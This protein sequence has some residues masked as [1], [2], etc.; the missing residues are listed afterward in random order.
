MTIE[1]IIN[2]NSKFNLSYALSYKVKTIKMMEQIASLGNLKL[3]C[4]KTKSNP[5]ILTSNTID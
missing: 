2:N 1:S 3:A 5:F 4:Y